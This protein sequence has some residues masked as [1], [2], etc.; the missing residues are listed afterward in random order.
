[1]VFVGPPNGSILDSLN[2]FQ[3]IALGFNAPRISSIKTTVKGGVPNVISL[4]AGGFVPFHIQ[5]P[6]W[7]HLLKKM[8]RSS[9]S[10][11]EPS[12]EAIVGN[13]QELKLRTVV[14]FVRVHT[15][16]LHDAYMANLLTKVDTASQDWRTVVYLT[17][18]NSSPPDAPR[19]FT[20]GDVNTLPFSYSASSLPSILRDGPD[21]PIAK[22]Y[23]IP[24]TQNTPYPTL[25][26]GFP[27]VAV[28]LASAVYDSRRTERDDSGGMGR[29]AKILDTLYPAEVEPA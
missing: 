14:Q 13:E 25:P 12:V 8:A 24:A 28:Y 22:Y 1:M 21:G 4:P 10:R 9:G 23:T 11:I 2:P 29:L 7:H 16:F 26:I 27:S 17:I 5:A 20:N 18:D 6:D 15:Q 19:E 3:F